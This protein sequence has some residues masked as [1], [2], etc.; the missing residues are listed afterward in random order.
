MGFLFQGITISANAWA[1]AGHAVNLVYDLL[2]MMGR[3]DVLVGVG[4]E[5]GISYEG[6]LSQDVGGYL[7][8]IEQGTSTWG[9]CR[10]RQAIP[11]GQGG[12][13]D[14]DT[15]LGIR[16]QFLPQGKRHYE[17][18]KQPTAQ[19]VMLEVLSRGRTTVI[20]IGSHTNFATLL[21][22]H[23]EVKKIVDRIFIMGGG[24]KSRN[25]TGCCPDGPPSTC[26]PT[27]CGNRG[28]LFDAYDT[29]PWAEFNIFTDPFAAYQVVHSGLPIT[30]VPLDATNTIPLTAEFFNKL[31]DNQI[32]YEA[33]FVYQVVDMTKET[34]FNDNF[35]KEYFLWDSFTSGVAV[36]SI[37]TN[38][39]ITKNKYCVLGYRKVTVVTSNAPYGV[40]DGSNPSF[41][42]RAVPR[43]RL[44]NGSVHS[45]HVQT[46][47][48]DSFCLN[49]SRKEK[50]QD[51]YTKES[52]E[53]V[54]IQVGTSAKFPS[55]S[56]NES[57]FFFQ[58]S[59]I[60]SLNDP[61]H[62]G[63][64]NFE[65]QYPCYK[66]V[67]YKAKELDNNAGTPIIFDMDIS[68]GDIITLL[69]LLKLPRNILDLK[70][71]TVSATGWS[72]AAT[73]DLV[74]DILHMM[75]RDEIPV[76]LGELFSIGQAYPP[77][78]TTGNC[79]Y[80]QWIPNGAGGFIDSDTLFGLARELPRSPR[81]Y[82]AENSAVFGAPRDTNHPERRQPKAQEVIEQT[83][84]Q[85]SRVSFLTGG[86]LTNIATF[87]ASK[88]SL[89]SMVKEIFI[90]GG[91]IN[92][93]NKSIDM[94]NVYTLS[95]NK[96]S[97]FNFFL[98]P[99]AAK[100]TLE[101]HFEIFL[102]P[103]DA[104]GCSSLVKSI[105]NLLDIQKETPEA[106]FVHKLLLVVQDLEKQNNR[107]SHT[108]KLMEEVVAA[109]ALAEASKFRGNLKQAQIVVEATGNL[110]IDGW[111]RVVD[112]GGKKVH[113][114][115]N[116]ATEPLASSIAHALNSPFN[117][118]VLASFDEQV[119]SWTSGC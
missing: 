63:L 86:P 116:M 62:T 7:P 36:S 13:L 46:G 101:S 73:I 18:L 41:D 65:T 58:T 24:V 38:Y 16:K 111:T 31:K 34:W 71:I 95:T 11:P 104:L 99:Q 77:L 60:E 66:E 85:H 109:V 88:S 74:Y 81:R 108:A 10:Y 100:K 118:A 91:S 55:P 6:N 20:L 114:M 4:G 75:G 76:G 2:Y 48:Q 98:D 59:F 51:G 57:L 72:S 40:Q 9:G 87:L 94:G 12:L 35:N 5:G 89:Q 37:L 17:P 47:L 119:N 115:S 96:R 68:P 39:S 43:F 52:S 50:C 14:I 1:D 29:N 107:Y 28:N 19:A 3:D 102:F 32:T 26:V 70:G 56:S 103:L 22:T 54:R 30:L 93:S 105:I 25:P 79:K 83:L 117:T 44:Q 82:T 106:R 112:K 110:A 61:K 27:Q 64:Y 21:M 45:G 49:P 80:R 67:L 23:P 33:Q 69:Y 78:N 53:G 113:Y 84:Q 15:M 42:D 92:H 97:E 90:A 8:L